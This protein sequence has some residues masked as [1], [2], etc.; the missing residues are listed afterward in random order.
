MSTAEFDLDTLLSNM[1]LGNNSSVLSIDG[2]ESS[3]RRTIIPISEYPGGIDPRLLDLSYSGLLNL[4]SCPR[5]FELERK[6]TIYAE[7]QSEKAT[8]T[9]AFGHVVGAG[10]ASIFSGAPWEAVVW[11]A[12]LAW[13]APLMAEDTKADKSFWSALLALQKFHYMRASGFLSEY[14]VLQYNGK[15]AIELGFRVSLPDSFA[16]RGYIDVVLQHQETKAIVV[17]EVKT[18]GLSTV[19]P[20]T[21]KNSSQ[22]IGYSI[23]LDVVAPEV[24]HYEVYYLVYKTKGQEFEIFP[25]TK[26]YTQRAQWIRSLLFDKQAIVLY[27]QENLFPM[28]G[29]SCVRFFQDCKYLQTCQLSTEYLTQPAAYEDLEREKEKVYE[30]NLTLEDLINSQLQ[31]V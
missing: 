9:Y 13:D 23:V 17:I 8:I 20:A 27:S 12:F 11:E 3:S 5:Y 22:A 4:H 6:R 7:N 18:T 10:I 15:P 2:S 26:T 1:E 25:F 19:N 16:I 28:R 24:S 29:E 31:K 14:T 21:Y 30:I